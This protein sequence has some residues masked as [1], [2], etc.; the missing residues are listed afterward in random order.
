MKLGARQW[1]LC[2]VALAARRWVVKRSRQAAR[3]T[4]LA[5]VLARQQL[6][7]ARMATLSLLAVGAVVAAETVD[8]WWLKIPRLTIP[9]LEAVVLDV[10][11][12]AVVGEAVAPC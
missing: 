10:V 11:V 9:R 8:P 1:L 7:V 12:A 6:Q 5:L 4:M 2:N 3:L